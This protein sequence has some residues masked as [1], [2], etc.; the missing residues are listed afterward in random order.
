MSQAEKSYQRGQ[1]IEIIQSV[2]NKID[3]PTDIPKEVYVQLSELA[4]NI[5][6]LR[7]DIAESRPRNLQED[8]IPTAT[9][10]LDAVVGST[11]EAT[12]TIMNTCEEIENLAEALGDSEGKLAEC[13]GKIYEACSF[14]DITGQRISKVVNTLKNIEQTI[15]ILMTALNDQVGPIADIAAK[16][17]EKNIGKALAQGP[18]MPDKA[19]SQDDIDKLLA[20]FDA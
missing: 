15:D 7:K 2:V 1:V 5:D 13:T 16:K 3:G 4:E 18:Q 12:N 14:Q 9:D 8:D 17:E 6:K 10:E 20:E 19:I 11:A